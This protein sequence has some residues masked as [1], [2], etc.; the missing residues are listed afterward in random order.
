MKKYLIIILAIILFIMMYAIFIIYHGN[1]KNDSITDSSILPIENALE[2][3][4][5]NLFS[6][7]AV[8]I[9]D[10][11]RI[12]NIYYK[13]ISN[14]EEYQIYKNKFA[15]IL[16]MTIADFENTFMIIT[17]TENVSASHLVPYKIDIRDNTLYLGMEKNF[18]KNQNNAQ[19]SIILPKEANVD[20][21]I[22]YQCID[23]TFPT[24]TYADITS[25]PE[26]YPLEQAQKDFCYI[27]Y[28]DGQVYNDDILTSFLDAVNH[29]EDYYIR[30]IRYSS[31]N[32]TI[33]TD[34]YYSSENQVFYV[35]QDG[36]R[37]FPQTTFN[38]YTFTSLEKRFYNSFTNRPVY[39]LTDETQYDFVLYTD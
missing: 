25:L 31:D 37:A 8:S 10:L 36:S 33:I 19:S 5:Y 6:S 22:I 26:D 18:S 30:M 1:L 28:K 17:Y 9:S 29:N 35:C 15:D 32:Q 13:K 34:V 24:D 12:N 7:N 2:I 21:T 3:K 14:Y 20:N 39:Y 11:D 4:N 38:Y 23:F 27:S 16:D